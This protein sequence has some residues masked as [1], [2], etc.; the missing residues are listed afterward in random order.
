MVAPDRDAP[1]PGGVDRF[2]GNARIAFQRGTLLFLD[3]L[4]WISQIAMFVVLGL[5]STPSLLLAAAPSGFAVAAVLIVLF[6]R[7]NGVFADP[8]TTA[9]VRQVRFVLGMIGPG[10]VAPPLG[11]R[12]HLSGAVRCSVG[13][14]TPSA[15]P[16]CTRVVR[17]TG[18]L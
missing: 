12:E 11:F 18:A 14:G 10:A 16:I 7:A 2:I 9:Y 4:A 15:D 8:V 5:L 3:G 13:R 6:A 1:P 17:W